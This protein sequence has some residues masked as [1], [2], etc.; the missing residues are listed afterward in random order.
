MKPIKKHSK[1][2]QTP[3]FMLFEIIDYNERSLKWEIVDKNGAKRRVDKDFVDKMMAEKSGLPVGKYT[4]ELLKPVRANLERFEPIVRGTLTIIALG[5][6][7]W[8]R[9]VYGD[10]QI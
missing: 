9:Q 5:G 7:E 3:D 1:L 8:Q 6:R 2:K 10:G 4:K